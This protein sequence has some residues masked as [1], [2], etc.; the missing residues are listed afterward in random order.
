IVVLTVDPRNTYGAGRR[1]TCRRTATGD[2]AT[3]ELA[4]GRAVAPRTQIARADPLAVAAVGGLD[5]VVFDA[6]QIEQNVVAILVEVARARRQRGLVAIAVTVA[7]N[8]GRD[9]GD[10]TVEIA[11]EDDVHHAGNGVGTVDSGRAILQH[12]DAL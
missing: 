10:C 2:R 8:A 4:A 12:F 6:F 11:L 7:G 3:Q 5:R 9:L 1:A